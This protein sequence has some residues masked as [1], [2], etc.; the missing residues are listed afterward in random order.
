MAHRLEGE[1]AIVTGGGR[2]FGRA[3]AQRFAAEGAKVAVTART[4]SQLDETVEAIRSSGGVALAFAGDVSDR[5]DVSRVAGA[6][7]EQLGPVS[8]LVS[9]AGISGPF[10]PIWHVDPDAWWEAQMVHVRGMLLYSRAVLPG[11]VQRKAGRIIIV[12][13]LAARIV[14]K[15]FSAYSVSKS[16]QV[17]LTEHLAA[18]VKEFGITAFAIEPGT[19]YTDLAKNAIANPDVRRWRP[20]MAERLSELRDQSDPLEGLAKC[21]ELCVRLASGECDVLSGQYIDVRE[22]LDE[23]LRQAASG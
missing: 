22:D 12:S 5:G 16:T 9:N 14:E 11:M 4:L 18:E 6:V 21:A 19:V 7:A 13:A 17:R 8:L 15:N 1:I 23:K 10:G 3:I 2:G 20:G